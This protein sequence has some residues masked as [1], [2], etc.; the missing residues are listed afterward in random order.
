M[1]TTFQ[2]FLVIGGFALL[3]GWPA[4]VRGASSDAGK[5]GQETPQ[6]KAK[7]VYTNEDLQK[8]KDSARVNQS[9]AAKAPAGAKNRS[10]AL[11]G[12]RDTGGHDREYW[13]KKVRPL[14]NQ[15]E[16]LDTQIAAQQ[17][18]YDRL[19]AA[20]GVKLSR[21]GKL[22]ASSAETRAQVAKRIGDLQQKR[23]EVLKA[24]QDLEE[25]ARKAQA[26]PEWLR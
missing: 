6:R 25:E 19:N 16:T 23:A 4:L 10:M 22:R 11:E 24:K 7:K 20:S 14:N 3:M 18:K 12:Y 8:L 5:P 1:C 15:L 17:A 9:P 13:Q 26:L 21:S 2:Q